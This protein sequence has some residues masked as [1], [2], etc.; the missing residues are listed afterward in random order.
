M[1]YRT[2][3]A[4]ETDEGA[5]DPVTVG[6]H[7]VD[8]SPVSVHQSWTIFHHRWWLH[9]IGPGHLA[10]IYATVHRDDVHTGSGSP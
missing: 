1:N 5:A 2:V 8:K 6:F 9:Y 7:Q 4:V 3:T 10:L